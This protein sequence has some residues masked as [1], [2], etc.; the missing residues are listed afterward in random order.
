MNM[1]GR[2]RQRMLRS[3]LDESGQ[4]LIEYGLLASIIA[5]AGIVFLPTIATKMGVNFGNWG[6]Q[7]E[8]LWRPN[9]PGSLTP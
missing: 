9:S 7:V 1:Q 5:I 4:D 3:F 2:Y 6:T 8:Q